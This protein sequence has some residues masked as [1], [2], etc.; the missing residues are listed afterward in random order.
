MSNVVLEMNAQ[1]A[2]RLREAG[3]DFGNQRGRISLS[4]GCRF[5]PPFFANVKIHPKTAVHIGAFTLINGGN[6]ANVRIGRYCSIADGVVIG[7]AEHPLDRLTSSTLTFSPNFKNWGSFIAAAGR[8]TK[9]I[10]TPFEDRRPVRIGND[11]WIGLGA[12]IR[13]GVTVG[14]GAVIAAHACV[15]ADV[16]PYAIVGGVPAR[17][18]RYRF[19][20]EIVARHLAARWW[21]YAISEIEGLDPTDV[22]GSLKLFE[23]K[24]FSYEPYKPK[25]LSP[26]DLS[27]CISRP[28]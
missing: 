4:Q 19:P 16:P 12:Y 26:S 7:Q 25:L 23:S 15:V 13:A 17:L 6:I 3:V 14:D 28:R 21:R 9:M 8:P 27:Q 2:D 24:G 11:V 5:E 1:A 10:S 18:I 20:E 22:E